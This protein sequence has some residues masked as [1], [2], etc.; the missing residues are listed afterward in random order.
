M[1]ITITYTQGFRALM[2]DSEGRNQGPTPN[3]AVALDPEGT[4]CVQMRLPHNDVEW[5]C[6][7]LCKLLGQAKPTIVLM[8]NSFEA[9]SAFTAIHD[10]EGA[11][12]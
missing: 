6:V 2:Q 10:T 5:R 7:W 4:H 12:A 1:H 9:F 3:L 11:E 8:D